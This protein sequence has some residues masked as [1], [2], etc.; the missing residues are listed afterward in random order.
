MAATTYEWDSLGGEVMDTRSLIAVADEIRDA[1]SDYEDEGSELGLEALGCSD[2]TPD[3]TADEART[4]LESIEEIES[5]GLADWEYGETLIREDYF[6]EYA[7]ELA[8]DIGAVDK[9]ASWPNSYI[10]WNAAADALKMDYTEVEYR[11][12]TYYARA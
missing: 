7:Q 4:I 12:T 6:T 8:A 5:A 10:D 2:G 1:L 9:D 11:G 3:G